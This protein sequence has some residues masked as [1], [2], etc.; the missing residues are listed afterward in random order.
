MTRSLRYAGAVGLIVLGTAPLAP[1]QTGEQS[2]G[3]VIRVTVDLVQVDAVVTDSQGRHVTGL[4][5]EDFEILEDGKPQKI[6]HFSYVA[7][8]AVADGPAIVSPAPRKNPG[9]TP[10]AIPAPVKALR[11]EE[12]RRTIVLIADNLGLSSDDIPNVRNAMKSFIERQMQAGDLVSIMTTSGGMGAMQQLT[13]DKRQL[14]ASIERIHYMPGR[15]GLTWYKPIL[16]LGPDKKFRMEIE[17]RLNAARSPVLTLGTFDVLAYAIQG[18]REMPGRKAIALFSDGFPPAA[19]GIIQLA[20]RASVAIY[21]LDPR[22]LVSQ[23]FTAVDAKGTMTLGNGIDNDEAKRLAAYRDTQKGLEQLAQGTGG[24][25]FHDDNDLSQGLTKALDDMS[26]YYLI[27]YQPQSADFDQVRGLPKFHKTDVKVLRAGLQVR[28][29]NGFVGVPDP[30]AVSEGTARES[31]EDELRRALFSPFQANG[32]PVHLSAFYSAAEDG[33]KKT[34]RLQTTL[35]TLMVI[36]ARGLTP[37]DIAGGRKRLVLDVLAGIWG[38]NDKAIAAVDKTFT[39]EKTPA[40]MER[41]VSQ[42]LA[43]EVDVPVPKPGGYQLRSAVREPGSGQSG[44]ATAFVQ[45]PDFNRRLAISSVL[46]LDRDAGRAEALARAGVMA[47]GGPAIR[48][49]ASGA[50]LDY[51][52]T[53]SGFQIDTQT[54]K[55]KL[56]VAVRLFRGPEQI[57]TGRPIALAMADGNSKTAVH[58]AG[59]IKLPATLPPGDY[60]LELI[61]YDRLEKS[62]PQHAEQFVDF[63]LAKQP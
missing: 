11:P 49:F 60:A 29:R 34:H 10:E 14:Y 25:F 57:Y 35:R 19:G 3:P 13:N 20:N 31:R 36:D 16:P 27:G 12:V 22:G 23:F 9:K 43:V 2:A 17:Q 48:V 15:T 39:I 28:S 58:A 44:S 30:P 54:G 26:S 62:K 41:A 51:D 40:E 7:G 56:D 4:K 59:E 46:L 53:V 42:G 45:I 1:Q 55:P 33:A 8:N 24:I 37:E 32:F 21:T 5:P 6:T 63:S 50:V 52:C 18:L 61:A 47:A 38:E